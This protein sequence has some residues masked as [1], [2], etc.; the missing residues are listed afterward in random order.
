MMLVD[1]RR[2]EV[3]RVARAA[4]LGL[5]L[6]VCAIA[7]HA[8]AGAPRAGTAVLQEVQVPPSG[9]SANILLCFQVAD[10]RFAGNA[11]V[12]GNGLVQYFDFTV[13]GVRLQVSGL[14]RV[15]VVGPGAAL[16]PLNPPGARPAREAGALRFEYYLGTWQRER[17]HRIR[18]TSP[19]GASI[20]CLY[21][22]DIKERTGRLRRISETQLE[23]YGYTGKEHGGYRGGRLKRIAGTLLNYYHQAGY[24]AGRVLSVQPPAPPLRFDYHRD[25]GPLSGLVRTVGDVSFV[26]TP[27][28]PTLFGK[29]PDDKKVAGGRPPIIRLEG[30]RP[31]AVRIR[32][33]GLPEPPAGAPQ[34]P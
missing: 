5:A 33:V 11:V 1:G 31:A 2:N 12:N 10:P 16:T 9:D 21:W 34:R 29:R 28:L 26:Y 25:T 23:Y 14:G 13:G 6:L 8:R 18:D 22:H 27:G 4:A 7:A 17:V 20:Y 30:T 19:G 15:S 24:R 3:T 32:V